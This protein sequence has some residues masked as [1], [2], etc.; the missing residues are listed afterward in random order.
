MK[1]QEG[2]S[3]GGAAK[4]IGV[5][6]RQ[7]RRYIR[8]GKLTAEKIP[9]KFGEEY[10]ISY[11]PDELIKRKTASEAFDFTSKMAMDIVKGLQEENRNLAGQLGIAQE[12][13]RS[14]ENQVRL[15]TEAKVPFWRRLFR[16]IV[17]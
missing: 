11:I 16:R 10:R 6:T 17:R 9:G 7:V 2:Y 5:S 15:L 3:I 4:V 14:L 13:I 12:R 8:Q 1:Q